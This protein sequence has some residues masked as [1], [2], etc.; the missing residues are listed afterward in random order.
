MTDSLS[1]GRVPDPASSPPQE[2]AP[3]REVPAAP[4]TTELT[5]SRGFARWLEVHDTSLAFSSYQ[6]GQLFLI[7]R[8]PE[9][10]V[11]FH[12]RDFV[13]AMGL[14]YEP[15]RLFL[16]SMLQVWRLENILASHERA[17][18]HFD[19]LF[20]PRMARITGDIDAHE[21][22]VDGAGRVVFV[23]TKFSCLAT[24]SLVHSFQPL[25]KPKFISKLAAEDRCHLNGLCMDGGR[26]RFV[27]AVSRTDVVDGWRDHRTG[28]GV[29]IAVEDDAI[30]AEGLSMPHSPRMY[31]GQLYVL[32]S[33]RGAL[34]RIDPASGTREDIAFCPGF[35]RGLALHNGHAVVTLS[36]PRYLNFKGL[37][38]DEEI[39]RRG[40][41]PWCGVQIINLATGDVVE[42]IRLD[43]AIRELFDVV[44]M[45][46]M[47][48]P[49]AAPL[50]GGDLASLISYE[51]PPRPLDQPGWA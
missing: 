17:N 27:T 30:V 10:G 51:A 6:T 12:Q 36:L 38:L 20:V 9:G 8:T 34:V 22:A 2:T 3:E 4:E 24:F 48:C 16:A 15:N 32:D 39:T 11:S 47:A 19:R 26:P 7:G 41:A 5:C 23:N 50:Q 29:V 45:P 14:W 37:P 21:L 31:N 33:G 43:G 46:G 1:P 44:V 18:G 35:M 28:G 42:W 25:W 13:R 40:G 49:M